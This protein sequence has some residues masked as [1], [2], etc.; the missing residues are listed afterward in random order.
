MDADVAGDN[1]T[2]GSSIARQCGILPKGSQVLEPHGSH[3]ELL[4]ELKALGPPGPQFS[5]GHGSGASDEGA[6]LNLEGVFCLKYCAYEEYSGS[7]MSREDLV[8]VVYV[9][10]ARSIRGF[11]CYV[12]LLRV[13]ATCFCMLVV[14][15]FLYT[16]FCSSQCVLAL[17]NARILASKFDATVQ[18]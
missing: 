4:K 9:F 11:V 10:F 16:C 6:N 17:A 2:T 15:V 7:C 8:F 14:Y 13:F 5:S 12:F 3:D 18:G 1:A